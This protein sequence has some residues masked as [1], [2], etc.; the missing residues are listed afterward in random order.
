MALLVSSTHPELRTLWSEKNDLAFHGITSTSR[1]KV[2]WK[3]ST[4]FDHP[5]FLLRVDHR[6]NGSSCPI[7]GGTKP[8]IGVTD[9]GSAH[10]MKTTIPWVFRSTFSNSSHSVYNN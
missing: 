6:V 8:W 5:D 10:P 9:L 3:C 1:L 7:C 4:N 2:W